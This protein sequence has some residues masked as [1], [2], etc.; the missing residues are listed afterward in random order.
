M[1]DEQTGSWWQQVTG[2]AIQGPLKGAHLGLVD[3]DEISFATWKRENPQ[4]RV[5]RPD[6]K[7]EQFYE[8]ADWE[9]QYAHLRVVT[10][11]QLSDTTAQRTLVYG[12][13]MN[14]VS[15][16]YS[17][18]SLR[19][20]SPVVD[21]VGQRAVLIVME[22]DKKSVR[23]FDRSVDGRELEFF[24]KP[25]APELTLLDSE[26][27]SEWDFTGKAIGGPLKGR[28]LNK[29]PILADYWFDWKSYHPET[30]LYDQ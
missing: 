23:A 14:G 18:Q 26:T 7:V 27:G 20:Q 28:Q 16:A 12:L 9:E 29:L 8:P 19:K 1:K 6:S 4:G 25:Q 22:K 3:H 17:N 13:T 2:E 24:A 30:A 11:I 15:K 5:L 10:P 21:H